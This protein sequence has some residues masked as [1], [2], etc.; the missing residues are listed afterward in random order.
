MW[1]V[2]EHEGRMSRRRMWE[3]AVAVAEDVG[4]EALLDALRAGT[5][6]YIKQ[7]ASKE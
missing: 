1:P 6:T 2:E 4:D 5:Y 7:E 3:L